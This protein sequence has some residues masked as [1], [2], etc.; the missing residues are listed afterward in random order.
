MRVELAILEWGPD[1]DLGPRLL[2]RLSDPDLV[3]LARQRLAAVRRRELARLEPPVRLVRDEEDSS[4]ARSVG[5]PHD[6]EGQ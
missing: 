5:S 4:S 1:P 3:Q 2:G 6:G